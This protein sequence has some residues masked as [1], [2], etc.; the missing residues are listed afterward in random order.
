MLGTSHLLRLKG[1]TW[2]AP[3]SFVTKL[4]NKSKLAH[5]LCMNMSIPKSRTYRPGNGISFSNEHRKLAIYIVQESLLLLEPES[6]AES[7]GYKPDSINFLGN[8]SA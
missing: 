2:K 8:Y 1:F 7:D 5:R 6:I 3:G 4:E